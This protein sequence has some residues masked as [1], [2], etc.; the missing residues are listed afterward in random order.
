MTL[1][2]IRLFVYCGISPFTWYLTSCLFQQPHHV[3]VSM[4]GLQQE[5]NLTQVLQVDVLG[6]FKGTE[7]GD[8]AFS[9]VG[10][11]DSLRLFHDRCQSRGCPTWSETQECDNKSYGK[12]REVRIFSAGQQMFTE[13]LSEFLSHQPDLQRYVSSNP[14]SLINPQNLLLD[15]KLKQSGFRVR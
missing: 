3:V 4:L 9:D 14:V 8:D 12:I 15:V 2:C 7:Y 13:S 6:T 1:T 5:K 11:I 10:Q